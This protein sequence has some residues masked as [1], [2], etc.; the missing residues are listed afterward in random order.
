M[1]GKPCE[2]KL[3]HATTSDAQQ[4][5]DRIK[6]KENRKLANRLNVYAC[7]HCGGYHVGHDRNKGRAKR[8]TGVAH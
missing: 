5:M 8:Y 2:T 4:H 1:K 6:P 3:R 7:V